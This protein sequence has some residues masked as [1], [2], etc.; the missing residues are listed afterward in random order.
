M[1][2]ATDQL[3]PHAEEAE[4][5]ALGCVLLSWSFDMTALPDDPTKHIWDGREG[6]AL[7]AQ[8]RPALF[9]DPKHRILHDELVKMRLEGHALEMPAVFLWLRDRKLLD[10]V[11]GIDYVS[12]LPEA[13][14]SIVN[15]STYV[16][17]LRDTA[18]RRW[19][20]RR[21]HATI[22]AATDGSADQVRTVAEETWELE[23]KMINHSKPMIE[24]IDLNY[25]ADFKPDPKSYLIGENLI[26]RGD[27]TVIAGKGGLGKSMLGNTMAFAGAR[28]RGKWLDY[29]VRCQ[30]RTFILQSENS[31]LR[32]QNEFRSVPP[33]CSE[34]VRFSKPCAL[35]FSNPN[36]RGELKRLYENWPFGMIQI[37]NWL[38]VSSC[39]GQEDYLEALN[40]VRSCFPMDETGPAVVIMAH[41]R[42]TRGGDSWRPKL[43]RALA[44][45]I[46]G[47]M[48]LVSKARVAFVLQPGSCDES[49]VFDCAKVNNGTPMAASAWYRR[50][51]EFEPY[52]DF[53]WNAWMNPEEG[54]KKHDP[55]AL[56][57][58]V[59][60]GGRRMSRKHMA[61]T[62]KNEYNLGVSTV[63][64]WIDRLI[65][66]G[67]LED[68]DG[69]IGWIYKDPGMACGM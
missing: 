32:M 38:D 30:W 10:Q 46:S 25:I 22:S 23:K 4:R 21:A 13:T 65:G 6:D 44:D 58:R 3:P 66:Y 61:D 49:V 24:I 28:G 53:D 11:G 5:A 19:A 37:D 41:V 47:S 40:N 8:L 56:F 27:L 7:L 57:Q 18:Y 42:K 36:F 15:F 14:P 68:K 67:K 43:G 34:F 12:S 60:E 51:V 55:E 45:E 35:E 2:K 17:M 52:P 29:D 1:H 62:L 64:R 31:V 48:A 39:E 69:L 59:L 20:I 26:C 16:K 9:Y 50:P 33:G 63:Y 54:K